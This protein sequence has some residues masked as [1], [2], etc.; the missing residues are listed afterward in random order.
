MALWDERERKV[1]FGACGYCR[2]IQRYNRKETVI[3]GNL[4]R[5]VI[6]FRICRDAKREWN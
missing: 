3:P 2:G 1:I 4:S 5:H 6:H